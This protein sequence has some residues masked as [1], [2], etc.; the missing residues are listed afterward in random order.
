MNP[1]MVGYYC[2]SFILLPVVLVGCQA[3]VLPLRL[4]RVFQ[5][6]YFLFNYIYFMGVS[7]IFVVI[8]LVSLGVVQIYQRRWETA[9]FPGLFI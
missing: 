5:G 3:E 4:H 7:G 8:L 6:E 2:Y 9:L 1:I